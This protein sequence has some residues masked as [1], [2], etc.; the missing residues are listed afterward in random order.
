MRGW[1]CFVV[2]RHTWHI[3]T[4][5]EVPSGFVHDWAFGGGSGREGRASPPCHSEGWLGCR[6]AVKQHGRWGEAGPAT[7]VDGAGA[8]A[9]ASKEATGVVPRIPIWAAQRVCPGRERAFPKQLRAGGG[10]SQHGPVAHAVR[11]FGDLLP[12]VSRVEILMLLG[13]AHLLWVV[14][15]LARHHHHFE[16]VLAVRNPRVGQRL[17]GPVPYCSLCCGMCGGHCC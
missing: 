17:L 14:P 2:K 8:G 12:G 5:R 1:L 16:R 4:W 3:Q 10:W 15:L 6:R 9:V 7:A 11:R 13:A